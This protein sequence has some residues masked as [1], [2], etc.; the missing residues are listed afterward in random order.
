MGRRWI[1]VELGAHCHTHIIPRLTKVIDG[2]DAGGVTGAVDWQGGGGF[3]YYRLAPS[4]L[5]KD[6]WD[7]WVISPHYN[8]AMLSEAMCKH[9]GYLYAPDLACWWKHGSAGDKDFIYVTTQTLT[10][11]Q[12]AAIHD[13]LGPERSLLICCSAFRADPDAFENIT[14]KKI[15]NAVLGRCEF[16]RDDYSLEIAALPDP[17][18]EPGATG[19]LFPENEP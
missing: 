1:M 18:P 6:R 10:H 4:L 8:A 13:E 19:E 3:R 15:P 11:E 14:L 12:L 7:N 17:A 9:E 5:E 16:G 2:E